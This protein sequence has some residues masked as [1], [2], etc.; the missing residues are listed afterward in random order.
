MPYFSGFLNKEQAKKRFRELALKLHPDVGGSEEA[1]KQ[2]QEEYETFLQSYSGDPL[3]FSHS[4]SSANSSSWW[5]DVFTK[6]FNEAW[7]E[8]KRKHTKREFY[9]VNEHID[10]QNQCNIWRD[11]PGVDSTTLDSLILM[12]MGFWIYKNKMVKSYDAGDVSCVAHFKEMQKIARTFHNTTVL[13]HSAPYALFCV[14]EIELKKQEIIL[15]TWSLNLSM[16]DLFRKYTRN[17]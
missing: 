6:P 15:T 9:E 10:F 11:S 8:E 17:S 13:N 16:K 12:C 14:F 5:A 4:G 1:M 2:L 3:T 7:E